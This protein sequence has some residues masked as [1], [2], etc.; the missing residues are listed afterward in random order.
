MRRRLTAFLLAC[1]AAVGLTACGGGDS[2]GSANTNAGSA[3]SDEGASHEIT[4]AI[5]VAVMSMDSSLA[6]DLNSIW[7]IGNVQE[8]LYVMGPDNS[9]VPALAKDM[10]VSDDG[11]T[12]TFTLRDDAKW[13]N[14]TPVTANDFVYGWRRLADPATASENTWMMEL[15][16]VK[17]CT[18]VNQGE[19]PVE[20]LGVAA[21]DDYTFVVTLEH[22]CSYFQA[23]IC[24]N[25]FL[26]LNEEF[27]ESKGESYALTADDILFNGAYVIDE[28]DVGGNTISIAKNDQYYDADQVDIDKVNFTVIADRQEALMA[29]ESGTVDYCT[30]NGVLAKA[31]EDNDDLSVLKQGMATLLMCNFE[32]PGLDNQ[33]FRMAV[34]Y[35]IDR[36][37]LVDSV[38]DDGSSVLGGLVPADLVSNSEGV[39]YREY[40][41]DLM[42]TDKELA[43]EYWEKA[44]SETDAREITLLYDDTETYA[45]VAAYIQSELEETL[46]G[47]TVELR[48]VPKKT[49]IEML[50]EGDFDLCLMAWGPDYADPITILSLYDPSSNNPSFSRWSS[51]LF[52]ADLEAYNGS[53]YINDEAGRWE[54]LKEMESEAVSQG[55]SLPLYQTGVPVLTRSSIKGAHYVMCGTPYYYKDM[56]I[57]E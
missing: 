15:T 20:E 6:N 42:S 50:G 5:D 27:V 35:A 51:D 9:P 56:T 12:Y 3:G 7:V 14:G 49:R 19:L 34:G 47:L 1:V 28:W 31:Y 40:A 36:E 39:D 53:E 44:K 57:E 54:L 33:N 30:I 22:P 21:P 55:A 10:E 2:A 29:Y 4:V 37:T 24:T 43:Q 23:V 18:A 26:P 41:G 11:L 46:D 45:K 13:S 16:G 8:G 38:L 48:S 52:L 17:N 25:S 32:T